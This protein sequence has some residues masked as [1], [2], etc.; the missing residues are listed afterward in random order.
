MYKKW[1][2]QFI[3][4][5][6]DMI[7]NRAKEHYKNDEERLRERQREREQKISIENYPKKK[8]NKTREYGRVG[9]CNMSK[10]NKQKLKESQ[11]K[12]CEAVKKQMG[13]SLL[14]GTL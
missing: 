5:E 7:L 6:T 3:I 14:D 2:K 9:Y 11:E 1:L 8:K 12:Y 10:E 13:P 4:K